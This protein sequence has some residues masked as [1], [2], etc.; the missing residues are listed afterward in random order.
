MDYKNGKIYRIDCLSTGE[1]YIGSTCQPTLAKRLAHHKYHYNQWKKDG[2]GFMNSFPII[3]RDNY[4]ITMIELYP[5][6]SRDEL[7]SREG[8]YI[9]NTE[10]LNKLIAGQTTYEQQHKW[11]EKNKERLLEERKTNYIEN[12]EQINAKRRE[13]Y[14]QKKTEKL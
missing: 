1:V 3:E 12:K 14:K 5:C 10:C 13:K 6:N 4:Q 8:Y 7:H 11:Y 9:R 2:K